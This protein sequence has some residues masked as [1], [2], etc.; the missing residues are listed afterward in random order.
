MATDKPLSEPE[1]RQWIKDKKLADQ[2]WV[3]LDDEE[4]ND[5]AIDLDEVFRI[6]KTLAG[7]QL[8]IVQV[9][10]QETD[11]PEFITLEVLKKP[12]RKPLTPKR[13]IKKLP[14]KKLP[15][16][17]LPASAPQAEAPDLPGTPNPPDSSGPT[18][19]M[20]KPPA[21]MPDTPPP[22]APSTPPGM[23]G[24]LPSTAQE[25]PTKPPPAPT[26]SPVPTPTP[27]PD[28]PFPQKTPEAPTISTPEATPTPVPTRT[29]A[30]VAT[31]LPAVSIPEVTKP[32]GTGGFSAQLEQAKRQLADCENARN[33]ANQANDGARTASES[34]ATKV[35][36]AEAALAACKTEKELR[37]REH[38][39]AKVQ[40]EQ[41]D[42]A[43][44]QADA[45]VKASEAK[46]THVTEE[47]NKREQSLADSQTE[48][49]KW[50]AQADAREQQFKILQD[51]AE[52]TRTALSAV[53]DDETFRAAAAQANSAAEAM[54]R[55]LASAKETESKAAQQI[56]KLTIEIADLK[57]KLNG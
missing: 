50:K 10:E 33:Q 18:S 28:S 55:A 47:L 6:H 43:C 9:S 7:Q 41:A 29:P 26:P 1:V 8:V 15:T 57:R 38:A 12:E 30:P 24:A 44:Q 36:E 22:V 5:E 53:D 23:P 39:E 27:T 56:N 40:L 51:S 2:W 4:F 42:K 34:A 52:T 3:M 20:A 49:A 37:N 46:V 48:Q 16:K 25:A 17:K 45:E 14:T 11:E 32:T 31:P 19:P 54:G 13:T 35:Q 21:G